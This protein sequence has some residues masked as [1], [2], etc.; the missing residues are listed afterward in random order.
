[1][2]TAKRFKGA[3]GWLTG[4]DEPVNYANHAEFQMSV[5]DIRI[6]FGRIE[7]TRDGGAPEALPLASIILSPQHA[8]AVSK[9]FAE[10]IVEY[11]K[12]FGP[13]PEPANKAD[14]PDDPA[15]IH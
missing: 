3:I 4:H 10:Q 12:R 13:I 6:R 15:D 8:K 9:V 2:S 11:E 1:M 14:Q 5:W 7:A